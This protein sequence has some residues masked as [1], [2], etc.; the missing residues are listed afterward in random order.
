MHNVAGSFTFDKVLCYKSMNID[1][2]SP[3]RGSFD[4]VDVHSCVGSTGDPWLD[5][6]PVTIF[7]KTPNP[8]LR[9]Y[10]VMVRTCRLGETFPC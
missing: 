2:L 10:F 8:P 6:I 5:C 9:A 7:Q 4:T 3:A 1:F